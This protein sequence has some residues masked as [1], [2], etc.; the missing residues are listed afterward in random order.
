[1]YSSTTAPTSAYLL[2]FSHLDVLVSLEQRVTVNKKQRKR[3]VGHSLQENRV[4]VCSFG[5]C[6]IHFGSC[7]ASA[8]SC[9]SRSFI[10]RRN[11][12]MIDVV[13]I[14]FDNA[15]L[16]S[17]P[18]GMSA[19]ILWEVAMLETWIVWAEGLE[20]EDAKDMQNM[21]RNVCELWWSFLM[22]WSSSW[23]TLV[24]S[25]VFLGKGRKSQ[26]NIDLIVGNF[27]EEEQNIWGWSAC[28]GTPWMECGIR[29]RRYTAR[30][31]GF[32]CRTPGKNDSRHDACV[33]KL[34]GGRKCSTSIHLWVV[35][36]WSRTWKTS[37]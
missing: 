18:L 11:K 13:H 16:S 36:G 6:P 33:A 29:E 32:I 20:W 37:S 1:M 28:F 24:V 26:S 31:E 17:P 25:Q 9:A 19:T 10:L 7:S 12:D 2:S 8:P 4:L 34:F 21:G 23:R 35:F 5:V 30:R 22:N 15:D 3:Q 14:F 27:G